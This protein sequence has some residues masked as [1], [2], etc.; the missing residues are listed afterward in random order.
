MKAVLAAVPRLDVGVVSDRSEAAICE[1]ICA[2][3]LGCLITNPCRK[4][5]PL[6]ASSAA[7]PARSGVRD[8]ALSARS[9]FDHDRHR[10]ITGSLGENGPE[11]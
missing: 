8:P 6:S 1:Q 5:D 11:R 4:V 3:S 7:G 9:T 10:G 2:R